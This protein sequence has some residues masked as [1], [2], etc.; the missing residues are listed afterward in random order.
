MPTKTRAAAASS[1]GHA[2][3]PVTKLPDRRAALVTADQL[4]AG[5]LDGPAELLREALDFTLECLDV[6][7][8][9]AEHK[10][11][12]VPGPGRAGRAVIARL[13]IGAVATVLAGG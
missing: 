5:Q 2:T 1:N 6:L 3:D 4:G 11:G 8:Q 13:R 10:I 7:A 9:A 12:A